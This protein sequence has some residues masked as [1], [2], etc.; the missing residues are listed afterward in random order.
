MSTW[1]PITPTAAGWTKDAELDATRVLYDEHILYDD[2][3]TFYNGVDSDLI[4]EEKTDWD[5]VTPTASSWT[6]V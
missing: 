3:L 5:S 2:P 1:N 6:A 4:N